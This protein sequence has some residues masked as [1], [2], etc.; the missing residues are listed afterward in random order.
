MD[1]TIII[2]EDA[3][4]IVVGAHCSLDAEVLDGPAI[5]SDVAILDINIRGQISYPLA[6]AL[7]KRHV[8]FI[9]ATGYDL[10]AIPAEFAEIPRLQKPFNA[11]ELVEAL[12]DARGKA[13]PAT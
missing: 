1:E 5:S 13:S 8:P 4:G 7:L 12:A 6:N 3:G 2:F 9:F 11:R 10:D